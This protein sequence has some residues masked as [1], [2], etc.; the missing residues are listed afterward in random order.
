[1]PTRAVAKFDVTGWEPSEIESPEGGPKMGRAL[2]RKTFSGDLEG[3]STT[4]MLSCGSPDSGAGY[5]A[6]ELVTGTL[7][8]RSGM[9]VMQHGGIARG[10]TQRAFGS[11]VPGSGTGELRGLHGEV[12]YQHDAG[13][14][15]VTLD[16]DFDES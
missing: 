16:Y 5:I 14:A 15:S 10:G 9:F 3:T 4:E 6:Q 12:K 2:I 1:M 11:I 8:G 13:G 7:A